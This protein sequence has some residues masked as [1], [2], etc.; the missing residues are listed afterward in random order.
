MTQYIHVAYAIG[1]AIEPDVPGLFLLTQLLEG[2]VSRQV[3]QA[4]WW[5]RVKLFARLVTF[6]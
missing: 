1:I 3:G 6:V 4:Y 5:C 2:G